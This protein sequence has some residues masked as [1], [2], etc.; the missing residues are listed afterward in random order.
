M[1]HS[2]GLGAARL[3][4]YGIYDLVWAR[5]CSYFSARYGDAFKQ[6]RRE[7]RSVPVF[8]DHVLH[9]S[10]HDPMC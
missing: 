5:R 8:G 1:R 9:K 6:K 7:N 10:K 2:F 3:G 4:G